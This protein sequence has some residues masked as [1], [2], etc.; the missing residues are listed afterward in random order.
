MAKTT[1]SLP[2]A[3]TTLQLALV[4]SAVWL[5]MAQFMARM[6]QRHAVVHVVGE[7]RALGDRLLVV[8]AR[9]FSA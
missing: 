1:G 3:L 4:A 6:A 7:M 8:R 2:E 5:E 9:E